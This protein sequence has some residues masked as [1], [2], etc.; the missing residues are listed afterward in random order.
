VNAPV[1]DTAFVTLRSP[2]AGPPSFLVLELVVLA[3]GILGLAH[4]RRALHAGDAGPLFTWLTIFVYGLAMELLSYRF[5]DN[6]TH[7]QFTVMFYHRKLPLYITTVYPA[8][9]YTAIATARRLRPSRRAEPFVAGLLIVA[10]DVPFDILG[11]VTGWWSWSDHDPNLAFR[12]LG[13]PVTSYYWHFAFGGILAALTRAATPVVR[14]EARFVL[15]L[16][17]AALTIVLGVVSF[18]PFHAL[19]A[20]GVADGTIV[21]GLLAIGA[22]VTVLARKERPV[23][24]DALLLAAPVL[25]YG[26]H[27]GL[28]IALAA[29]GT[30]AAGPRLLVIAAVIA[31]AAVAHAQA[32]RPAGQ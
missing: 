5:V 4:A 9:L 10:M 14:S 3:T 30:P 15:V 23:R 1:V 13:V 29:Q 8:L 27:L 31:L 28:A 11:P 20:L 21:A 16:P 12:W 26:A 6:F 22:V 2:L 24:R 25:F 17:V 18:V 32:H 7:G 19:K